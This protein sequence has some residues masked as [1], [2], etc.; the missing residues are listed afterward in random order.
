LLDVYHGFD[1]DV[2]AF[3]GT[4]NSLSAMQTVISDRVDRKDNRL[5]WSSSAGPGGEIIDELLAERDF[6]RC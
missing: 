6:W 5:L 1:A 4:I 3:L 2:D